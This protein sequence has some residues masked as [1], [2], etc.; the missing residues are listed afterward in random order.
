MNNKGGFYRLSISF[1]VASLFIFCIGLGLLISGIFN[2][3]AGLTYPEAT[4]QSEQ[5]TSVFLGYVLNYLSTIKLYF[6]AFLLMLFFAWLAW[7]FAG[8]AKDE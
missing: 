7:I 8:F 1:A 6:Y 5:L 4:A 2:V 3:L